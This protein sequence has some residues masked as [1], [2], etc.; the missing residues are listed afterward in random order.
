MGKPEKSFAEA[1]LAIFC[2]GILAVWLFEEE[3]KNQIR[4]RLLRE[5][6]NLGGQIDRFAIENDLKMIRGDVHSSYHQLTQ[7]KSANEIH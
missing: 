4:I 6:L 7:N 3:K 5:R 1:F 2:V